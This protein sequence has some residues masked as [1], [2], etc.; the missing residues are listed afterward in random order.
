LAGAQ[1]GNLDVPV[2]EGPVAGA[3]EVDHPGGER[4][5]SVVEEQQFDRG[6]TAGV[7]GE[8]DAT[9]GGD[10]AER[11]AAAGEDGIRR[12]IGF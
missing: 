10:G 5:V 4:V 1:T 11:C 12:H 6:R 8:V 9:G 7:D 2:V 3:V